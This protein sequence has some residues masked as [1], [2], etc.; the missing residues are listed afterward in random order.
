[1]L[2]HHQIIIKK[3]WNYCPFIDMV[4]SLLF[5]FFYFQQSYD[6]TK[7]LQHFTKHSEKHKETQHNIIA[8]NCIF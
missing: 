5:I 7:K 8:G 4:F 1:M 3:S 6:D 2:F